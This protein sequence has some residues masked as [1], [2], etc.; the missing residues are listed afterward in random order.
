MGVY[1]DALYELAFRTAQEFETSN[2]FTIA[3]TQW[4]FISA[5]ETVGKAGFSHVR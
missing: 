3:I 4:K 2:T 5:L 1:D